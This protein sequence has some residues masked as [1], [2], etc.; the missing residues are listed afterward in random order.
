MGSSVSSLTLCHVSTNAGEIVLLLCFLAGC[1]RKWG[2]SI[3][4][5]VELHIA[6]LIRVMS[7]AKGRSE[8]DH[9]SCNSCLI[10]H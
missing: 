7:E 2:F 3:N 8:N 10:M 4:M 5:R 9:V 6:W 1:L